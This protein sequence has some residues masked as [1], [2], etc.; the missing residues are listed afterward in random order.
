MQ[1]TKEI[2]SKSL[3]NNPILDGNIYGQLIKLFYPIFLG[4]LFQQLYNTIDALI[5]GQFVGKEALAAVGGPASTVIN[6][7]IGFFVGM[8][9]GA[10]VIIAQYYGAGN[11][12]KTQK[13]I[14][15][16]MGISVV[17]SVIL[18][19]VGI[20]TARPFLVSMGTPEDILEMS[21]SYMIIYY[22]GTIFNLIYNMGS[23]ILRS[24]GDSKRPLYFLI[25]SSVVNIVLDIVFVVYGKMGVNGVAY[26]TVISQI[27]SAV[28]IIISLYLLPPALKLSFRAM[29]FEKKMLKKIFCI[30]VPAGIQSIL[31]SLSNVIIQSSVNSFG[32]DTVAA[33]TT[34]SKIDAFFWSMVSS[35]GMAITTFAGQNYG[36]G[37]L[38]RLK[39][40]VRKGTIIVGS[41][42]IVM[43]IFLHFFGKPLFRLFVADE[44]VIAIGMNIIACFVPFYWTYIMIEILSG[45]LRAVGDTL[46]PTIMTVFGVC[47]LRVVWIYFAVP[48]FG[49]IE[50]VCF[51][52][53]LTW[54][55]TSLLFYIYYR[56]KHWNRLDTGKDMEE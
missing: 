39:Q 41:I 16:S 6:L 28:L 14:Q 42:T 32:T 9:S 48:K 20:L 7:L 22:S 24:M 3:G 46:I 33:W 25:V 31:Y 36:A 17:A 49:T 5:V 21:V 30:G 11:A 53:P 1:S 55:I 47:V 51:S 56:T 2:K 4:T 34:Y 15:M 13:A 29:T 45:V 37:R 18:T 8:A 54:S 40:S 52:Y 44:N 43:S 35:F 23:A 38:D 12:E 19:V 10:G 27:A 26:A 50:S